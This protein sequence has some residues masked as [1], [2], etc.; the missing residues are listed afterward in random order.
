MILN[1]L[2]PLRKPFQWRLNETLLAHMDGKTQLTTGLIK[3]FQRNQGS[4]TKTQVDPKGRYIILHK[5]WVRGELIA[6][7]TNLK[8]SA[9]HRRFQIEQQLKNMEHRYNQKP[10]IPT[11]ARITSLRA[12]L[13][14][15][16]IKQ[17]VKA[18][19][20]I[21]QRYYDIMWKQG[22]YTLCSEAAR[23]WT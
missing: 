2:P 8:K 17:A 7:A 6:I 3:Y 23:H 4:V 18:I 22:P 10:S 13:R 20:Y 11:L 9:A 14:D 5:V 21:R 19:T 1:I 16:N 12:Q 15:F